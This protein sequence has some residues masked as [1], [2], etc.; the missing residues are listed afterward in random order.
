MESIKDM[1]KA[2]IMFIVGS[3][4]L[5]SAYYLKSNKEERKLIL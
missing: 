1:N 2:K 4:A 5:A 3:V